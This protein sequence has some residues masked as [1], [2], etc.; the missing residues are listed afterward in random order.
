[1]P[2]RSSEFAHPDVAIGLTILAYRYEVRKPQ[3]SGFVLAKEFTEF[4]SFSLL[5]FCFCSRMRSKGSRFTLEVWGSSCV[6]HTLPN[7]PQ[8]SA[9]VR[10]RSQPFA[11]VRKCP[12]EVA[13]AMLMVSSAKGVTFGYFLAGLR[14]RVAGVALRDISPSFM[15]C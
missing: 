3:G 4:W 7:R 2:S 13:M 12:R 5:S 8:P 14:W 10:N 15:T 9:T 6:R 1:M 11:T